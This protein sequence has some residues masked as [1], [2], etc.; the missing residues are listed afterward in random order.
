MDECQRSSMSVRIFQLLEMM[1]SFVL[2]S[3]E[4]FMSNSSLIVK[5]NCIEVHVS[6]IQVYE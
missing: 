2:M 5:N 1:A 4:V 3:Y 6:G